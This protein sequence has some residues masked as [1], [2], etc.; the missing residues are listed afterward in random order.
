MKK[1]TADKRK[2]YLL[3]LKQYEKELLKKLYTK[4]ENGKRVE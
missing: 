3:K 1:E 2:E 4:K